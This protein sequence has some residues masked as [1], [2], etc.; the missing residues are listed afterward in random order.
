MLHII[1]FACFE[2]KTSFAA[3]LLNESKC[4]QYLNSVSTC[5]TCSFLVFE[6][7]MITKYNS[8]SETQ[9][10]DLIYIHIIPFVV[11]QNKVSSN[12]VIYELFSIAVVLFFHSFCFFFH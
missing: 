1:T 4:S 7:D 8:F 2:N 10:D 9:S 12:P 6:T 5:I 11:G 3:V